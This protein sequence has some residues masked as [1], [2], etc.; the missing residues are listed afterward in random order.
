MWPFRSRPA[1]YQ[2]AQKVEEAEHEREMRRISECRRQQDEIRAR[3]MAL[4]EVVRVDGR[5][6]DA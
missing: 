3:M 2:I 6:D 1:N 5:R 4:R